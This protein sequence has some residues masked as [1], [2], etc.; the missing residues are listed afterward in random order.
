MK[1]EYDLSSMKSRPNPYAARLK[2]PITM[3]LGEDVLDY[4]KEMASETGVPYQ[5][6]IN[7]YLRDCMANKRTIDIRWD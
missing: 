7:L 5:T 3:R 6:L 4:F 2:K 1:A